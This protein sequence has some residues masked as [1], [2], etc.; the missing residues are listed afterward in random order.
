MSALHATP[1]ELHH[2][3]P[4]GLHHPATRERAVSPAYAVLRIER[5]LVWIVPLP[6]YLATAAVLVFHF[7]VIPIDDFSRVANAYYVL[8]SRDPHL[9][10][11]GFVWNPLPSLLELPLVALKSVWPALVSQTFAGSI[12]SAPFMA[13]AV[14]QM[15]GVLTDTATPRFP[16][17]A[18][19]GLFAFN[20][21]IIYY[22]SNGMSEAPFI[23]FLIFTVRHLAKWWESAE[24]K[25]LVWAALGLGIA[26]LVRYEVVAA[27]MF[28]VLAVGLRTTRRTPGTR[29][30]RWHSGI[31]DAVVLGAPLTLA[32]AGWA[33][34][35]WMITGD[36]FEQF[37]DVY[38]NA[39]QVAAQP[40]DMAGAVVRVLHQLLGLEPLFMLAALL[41][42]AGLMLRCNSALILTTLSVLGAVV[43]F[44]FIAA[45]DGK[46][47][48]FLRYQ[49]VIIPLTTL[50]AGSLSGPISAAVRRRLSKPW[51]AMTLQFAAAV[52][53]IAVAAVAIPS[54]VQ[55]MKN[56]YLAPDES[57]ELASV[58]HPGKPI[59]DQLR[60][61]REVARYIDSLHLPTASV[62]VDTFNGGPIVL[63]SA[64]PQQFVITSDRDFQIV[65]ADPA[66]YGIKLVLV[67]TPTGL[68]QL[69][70]VN[71]EFPSLYETGRPLG[72]LV[73][74]FTNTG[75]QRPTWR[76]YAVDHSLCTPTR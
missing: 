33:A 22:A 36:P 57:I 47:P 65:L 17:L 61:E 34:V 1:R 69:N 53:G 12:L 52:V 42:I 27:G 15:H 14:V 32:V 56:P 45:S 6:L 4:R 43:L 44:Q 66:L 51:S 49:I 10:A 38:G 11:M 2:P 13:G 60:V 3:A 59:N 55:T 67:P 71:R 35:S 23:F 19:T 25:P 31:A 20:P 41:A 76:L 24:S 48:G 58:L 21:M 50:L 68:G 75:T 64:Q 8:Y 16:R 39:A 62:L 7:K 37:S 18:I 70:A 72:C 46:T 9:A 54:A 40:P 29:K 28:A 63:S 73:R 30:F 74:Q 26:Y 5:A